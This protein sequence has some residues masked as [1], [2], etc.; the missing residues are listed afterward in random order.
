MVS[1][2]RRTFLQG[3]NMSSAAVMEQARTLARSLERRERLRV[4]TAAR[5]RSSIAGKLGIGSGTL[6]NIVKGRVK[7]LDSWIRDKLQALLI[8]ELE[9][10]I[11][12]LTHELETARRSGARLDSEQMGEVETHLAAA[13]AILNAATT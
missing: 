4:G 9:A 6:E 12:R 13:K 2:N 11:T 5:A 10:E 7:R 1:T 3:E 8:R